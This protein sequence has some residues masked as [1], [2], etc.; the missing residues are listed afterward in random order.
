MRKRREWDCVEL[1]IWSKQRTQKSS[2][3]SLSK[4]LFVF[5]LLL[6]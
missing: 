6:S 3:A 4:T 5:F 2:F 1:R